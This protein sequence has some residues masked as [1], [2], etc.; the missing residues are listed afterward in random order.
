[1]NRELAFTAFVLV[2]FAVVWLTPPGTW[3]GRAISDLQG[4]ETTAL[5]DRDGRPAGG[6]GSKGAGGLHAAGST[7]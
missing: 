4:G 6:V 2:M 3:L 1:V 7:E 5:G